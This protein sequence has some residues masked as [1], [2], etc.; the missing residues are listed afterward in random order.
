MISVFDVADYFL[1]FQDDESEDYISNLK[2]QKLCYYAQ[3]F[4]LAL[5]GKRLFDNNILAWQ[6]GP[7]VKELYEKYKKHGS[8]KLVVSENFDINEIAE[9]IRSLL[10]E[11]YEE[12]G[13]YSA[14]RLRNMTHAEAPWIK[15]QKKS[16][17][18]ISDV[19]M[20]K[21]FKNRLN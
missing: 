11:I 2:L 21:F 18:I 20:E 13:Q 10:G 14:W 6:H 7:V 4:Y 19:E 8:G 15:A 3:G 12:Y 9:D 17:W 16:D 5:K 1:C